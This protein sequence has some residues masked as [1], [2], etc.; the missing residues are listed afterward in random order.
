MTSKGSQE[1][2]KFVSEE[3]SILKKKS[4]IRTRN[5]QKMN[6]N[7]FGKGVYFCSSAKG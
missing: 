7:K 4:A 6:S 5:R 2:E 3:H 1:K